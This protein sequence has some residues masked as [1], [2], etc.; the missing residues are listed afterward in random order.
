M[1]IERRTDNPDYD[2]SGRDE[3]FPYDLLENMGEAE[4][5][6]GLILPKGSSQ[7]WIAFQGRF[8]RYWQFLFAS[9]PSPGPL[10]SS[11]AFYSF[12]EPAESV[13]WGLATKNHILYRQ[14]VSWIQDR[15]DGD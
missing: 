11:R 1:E 15:P 2:P 13:R 10:A 5:R 3:Y 7:P 4:E 12:H 14:I 9:T 8:G 6:S